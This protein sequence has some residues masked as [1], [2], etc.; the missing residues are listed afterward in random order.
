MS[1]LELLAWL[2]KK[3]KDFL[4]TEVNQRDLSKA[5]QVTIHVTCSNSVLVQRLKAWATCGIA[6]LEGTDSKS[7][8][9]EV[10]YCY[11][12]SNNQANVAPSLSAFSCASCTSGNGSPRS[13]SSLSSDTKA[14]NT[15]LPMMYNNNVSQNTVRQSCTVWVIKEPVFR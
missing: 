10:F 5:D 13:H 3:I 2:L 6:M 7:S 11:E 8:T 1:Q 4:R 9:N 12:G 15:R 14:Q